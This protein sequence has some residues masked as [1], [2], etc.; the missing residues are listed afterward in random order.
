[1]KDI[2]LDFVSG[3]VGCCVKEGNAG[4]CLD[5]FAIFAP[6]RENLPNAQ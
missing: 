3:A 2:T 1:M 5:L 6:P 4:W